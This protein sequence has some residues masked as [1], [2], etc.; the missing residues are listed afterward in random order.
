MSI[1]EINHFT[2]SHFTKTTKKIILN[3]LLNTTTFFYRFTPTKFLNCSKWFHKELAIMYSMMGKSRIHLLSFTL[4][5]KIT[6]DGK[7]VCI[8]TVKLRNPLHNIW[9][10]MSTLLTPSTSKS[11]NEYPLRTAHGPLNRTFPETRNTMTDF[12]QCIHPTFFL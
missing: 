3:R 9:G 12:Y 11:T 7:P 4:I 1:F 10:K 6:D 5:V 2:K 8:L